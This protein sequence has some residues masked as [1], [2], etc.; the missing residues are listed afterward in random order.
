MSA[1]APDRWWFDYLSLA[2]NG[3]FNA[4]PTVPWG[5]Y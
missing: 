1:L 5:S 3:L 4:A 2:I